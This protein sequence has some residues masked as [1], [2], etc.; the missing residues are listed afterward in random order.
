MMADDDT[1]HSDG[2]G[3]LH[4]GWHERR[5]PCGHTFRTTDAGRTYCLHCA[6]NL[7]A[8]LEKS[9][10]RARPLDESCPGGLPGC[11]CCARA[12][13]LRAERDAAVLRGEKLHHDVAAHLHTLKD[14]AEQLGRVIEREHGLGLPSWLHRCAIRAR[15][16][17][18]DIDRAHR[19]YLGKPR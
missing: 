9:L 3:T 15:H 14:V 1:V 16:A 18:I 12:E 8:E 7:M 2:M 6:P 17:W 10:V 19:E 4:P 5:C 13:E 11:Q